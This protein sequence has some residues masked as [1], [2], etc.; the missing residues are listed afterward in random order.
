MN[1]MASVIRTVLVATEKDSTLLLEQRDTRS[2]SSTLP[3]PKLRREEAVLLDMEDPRQWRFSSGKMSL[4]LSA[5]MTHLK[6][7]D[8]P[9]E[10]S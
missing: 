2:R 10:V 5:E 9:E 8:G 4:L 6:N 3:I 1:V 7:L